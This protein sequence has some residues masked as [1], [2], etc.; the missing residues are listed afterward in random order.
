MYS[1]GKPCWRRCCSPRAW[2]R[3]RTEHADGSTTYAPLSNRDRDPTTGQL[4]ITC[5]CG[6]HHVLPM[7]LGEYYLTHPE[8]QA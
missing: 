2:T 7:T 3:F 6:R 5:F 4:W 8:V 1:T